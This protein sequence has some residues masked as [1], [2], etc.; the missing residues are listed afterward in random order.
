L[1]PSATKWRTGNLSFLTLIEDWLHWFKDLFDC[2][3]KGA[4]IA[5]LV[6]FRADCNTRLNNWQWL[7]QYWHDELPHAKL[8]MGEDKFFPFSKATAVNEASLHM[9]T[10]DIIVIL[11]ADCYIPG[12]VITQ[13]AKDI[14]A[15][16]RR[17]HKLW[18]IP[19]RHFFRLTKSAT[20]AVIESDPAKPYR[21]SS[22]PPRH[23]IEGVEGS[24]FG[25]WY[26]ALIQI[27]PTEAFVEVGGMDT[28]FRGWGGEDVSFMHAV[29]TMYAKHKTTNNDVLHL[30]HE[31]L[32]TLWNER[33]WAGQDK[34]GDN[35]ELSWRYMA[36]KGDRKRMRALL[37]E[38]LQ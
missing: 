25:H 16:R 14:R 15:A 27:M 18:Y 20:H 22:P 17:G 29:D 19:Y 37:N 35:N 28:R 2:I 38:R 13:C 24:A 30:W 33:R 8:I 6:P 34:S 5:L 3:D 9:L 10:H 31:K 21:F 26:G 7:E 32:G 11:D 12:S 36:V 4:G 1:K 23:D